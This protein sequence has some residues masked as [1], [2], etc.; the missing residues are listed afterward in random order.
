MKK[1]NMKTTEPAKKLS[2]LKQQVSELIRQNI[3]L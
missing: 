2:K 3:D 1:Y